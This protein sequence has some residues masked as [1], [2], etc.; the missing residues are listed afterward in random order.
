MLACWLGCVIL[1]KGL[2]LQ[3]KENANFFAESL[4]NDVI[5]L[6]VLPHELPLQNSITF[7]LILDYFNGKIM[8]TR[9]VGGKFNLRLTCRP[10]INSRT[11]LTTHS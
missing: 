1:F 3:A 7:S 2:E 9:S 5:F 4:S 11:I 8:N 10:Y 6:K